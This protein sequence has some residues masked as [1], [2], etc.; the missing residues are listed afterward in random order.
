AVKHQDRCEVVLVVWETRRPAKLLDVPDG[1]DGDAVE[2]HPD[3]RTLAAGR[4]DGS[5]VL[6]DL[7]GRREVRR[8]PPGPVPHSLRFDPTG[9]RVVTVSPGARDGIQVRDVKDGT[10]VASWALPES[11]HA[12]DW[13]PD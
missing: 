8:F 12:V 11:E 9:G 5:I 13:H 6:Y 7:D 4:R 2:F 1:V 3:G 10:V